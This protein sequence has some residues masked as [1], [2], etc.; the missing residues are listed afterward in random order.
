MVKLEMRDGNAQCGPEMIIRKM[1]RPPSTSLVLYI[2]A[3]LFF[4]AQ[5]FTHSLTQLSSAQAIPHHSAAALKMSIVVAPISVVD[6]DLHADLAEAAPTLVM[7]G[8]AP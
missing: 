3:Q 7:C 1:V 4:R 8:G 2:L 6:V 5:S